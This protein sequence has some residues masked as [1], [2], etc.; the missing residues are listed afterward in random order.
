MYEFN[1]K[2][3]ESKFDASLLFTDTDSLVYVLKTEDVYESFYK[4]KNLF[5][6]SNYPQHSQFFDFVNKKVFG[7]MKDELKG[8]IIS[9]FVRLKSKMYSLIAV[10]SEENKKTKGVN[11]NV[12]KK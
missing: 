8:K 6:F 12:V 2:Y 3:I 9:E 5:N 1:Y 4:R 11:R 10:D 7:R